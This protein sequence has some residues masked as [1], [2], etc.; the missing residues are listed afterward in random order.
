M[1]KFGRERVIDTPISEMGYMGAAV[2]AAATGLRPVPELMFNDFSGFVF[3]TTILAQ[4]SKMRYMFGRKSEN[5]DDCPYVP[6]CRR[7]CRCSTLG[8]ILWHFLALFQ[9]SK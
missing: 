9:R 4:G 5:S 6:W 3:L 1:P 8:I 2:G 7:K